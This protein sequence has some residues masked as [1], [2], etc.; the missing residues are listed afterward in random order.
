MLS[1]LLCLAAA[2]PH[3]DDAVSAWTEDTLHFMAELERLHPNPWFG[4]L[5]EVFEQAVDEFLGGLEHQRETQR[6][7][8]FM[9]LVARLT[10][11]GRDG[12][13]GVWPL[14]SRALPLHPYAFSDGWFVADSPRAELVGA[15][16]V[17]IGGVPIEEACARLAPLLAADNDW[18]R[19]GKLALA[20]VTLNLLDGVGLAEGRERARVLVERAGVS[21]E[22]VLDGTT[23]DAHHLWARP[24]LPTRPGTLWL[25]GRDQAYRLQVLEGEKALYVQRGA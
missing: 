15:R 4:C 22:L 3:Q 13:S 14:T 1:L 8:G 24:A 25:E 21:A 10:D 18:N 11:K 12:H 2:S 6:L 17:A 19:R 23:D 20:L 9:R 16:L 7:A 5:R